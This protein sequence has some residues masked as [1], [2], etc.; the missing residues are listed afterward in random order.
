MTL[1]TLREGWTAHGD[2]P[3]IDPEHLSAMDPGLFDED[4][5]QITSPDRS[6]TLDVGWYPAGNPEGQ[7]VCQA[8]YGDNWDEPFDELQTRHSSD[9]LSWLEQWMEQSEDVF[10]A[11]GEISNSAVVSVLVAVSEQIESSPLVSR[12]QQPRIQASFPTAV[13]SNFVVEKRT[14]E[15]AYAP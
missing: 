8:V 1:P 7:L 10:G 3:L 4:L 14:P 5:L 11:A 2:L 13:G 6:V 15:A 9:V 12:E